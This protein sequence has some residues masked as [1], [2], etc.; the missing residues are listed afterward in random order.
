MAGPASQSWL[1]RAAN[2][3][4]FLLPALIPWLLGLAIS[5]TVATVDP[6]NL[7]PWGLRPR[8]SDGNYPE[9][10]TPKL[11]R[12]VVEQPHD[13]LLV[14]GSQAMG[15]TQ[16]QLRREFGVE[17]AFNLS[18]SLTR[19]EDLAA[20]SAAAIRTPGLKRLIVELPFTAIEP[21]QPPAA[22]GAG[23]ISVLSA[24]WYALPDFGLD[25]AQATLERMEAGVF[26]NP[27]WQRDANQFVAAP[28]IVSNPDMM[29]RLDDAF[30]RV[31]VSSFESTSVLPCGDFPLISEYLVPLARRAAA[32][33]VSLDLYF[34][35]IPSQS[36]PE[37]ELDISTSPNRS[38]FKQLLSFH[39]C[40][41][42][43][44]ARLG[45]PNV[46]VHAID[47]DLSLTST[48]A[49]YR[50]SFHLVRA[51]AFER[52]VNDI[53]SGRFELS[54]DDAEPYVTALRN[55]VLAQYKARPQ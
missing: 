22:T 12:A 19:A 46:H 48:L 32:R 17:R 27:A 20:T 31:P 15:I 51:D 43:E 10:V 21:D 30:R 39:R 42:S 6:L 49:N 14:G 7:R 50:D 23:A 33:R 11:V 36:Y 3:R 41:I 55:R 1:S 18:Y 38:A 13:V 9:L 34:P 16:Q 4:L 53:R 5:V 47:L 24:P 37:A 28:A 52:L 35:P 45:Y 44:V 29:N 40:V 26:D 54:A 8:L 2:V 25:Y